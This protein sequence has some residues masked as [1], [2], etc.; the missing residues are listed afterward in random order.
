MIKIS[1]FHAAADRLLRVCGV[2]MI[3]ALFI[4]L[5]DDQIEDAFGHADQQEIVRFRVAELTFSEG[6]FCQQIDPNAQGAHQG[7]WSASIYR[8]QNF[9]CGGG[10]NG[11][12]DGSRKCFD[13]NAWT[14]DTCG[15]VPGVQYQARASWTP[16]TGYVRPTTPAEFNFT[17][18]EGPDE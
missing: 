10:G 5:F 11:T 2:G 1:D 3:V 4:V 7:T 17:Y 18:E 15:L 12:Y 9:I 8:K 16:V 6:K 14:G 13:P